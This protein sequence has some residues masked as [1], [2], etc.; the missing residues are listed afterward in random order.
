MDSE[1]G[2]GFQPGAKGRF[3]TTRLSKSLA[4]DSSKKVLDNIKRLKAARS[5]NRA[6]SALHCTY[7]SRGRRITKT[8]RNTRRRRAT[9]RTQGMFL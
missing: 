1:R 9:I 7:D 5:R 3:K 6:T 2:S 4:S 8:F